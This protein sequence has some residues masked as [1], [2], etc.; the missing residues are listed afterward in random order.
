MEQWVQEKQPSEP[1]SV[2]YAR[3]FHIDHFADRKIMIFR[4]IRVR[5]FYVLC[6]ELVFQ[7]STDFA[8]NSCPDEVGG[9]LLRKEIPAHFFHILVF[10][11]P[12]STYD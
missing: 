4:Q 1:H 8:R 3:I 2:K 5:S 7:F 12:R 9:P 6:R 11:D 10:H